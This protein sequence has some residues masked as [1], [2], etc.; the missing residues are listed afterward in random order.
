MEGIMIKSNKII[1]YAIAVTLLVLGSPFL[2]AS[3]TTGENHHRGTS[4]PTKM[5]P[6]SLTAGVPS[7]GASLEGPN[8]LLPPGTDSFFMQN[9]IPPDDFN[10]DEPVTFDIFFSGPERPGKA[11]LSVGILHASVGP[12]LREII[13]QEQL[14]EI[15]DGWLRKVRF[16]EKINLADVW[17]IQIGR[18]GRDA[19]V[20]T[21]PG[22]VRVEAVKISYVPR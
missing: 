21:Y 5:M 9:V 14:V 3:Q 4:Q 11:N 1:S 12:F 22:D 17:R 15:P 7:G 19:T 8:V 16:T 18:R 2:A 20:D 13:E 10:A 6:F